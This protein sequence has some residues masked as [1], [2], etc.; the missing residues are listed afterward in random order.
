MKT[1]LLEQRVNPD[2]KIDP[3]APDGGQRDPQRWVYLV[4]K[5]TN[6]TVPRIYD[7]LTP[8]EADVYCDDDAWEVTIK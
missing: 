2:W 4:Q 3:T 6:S 8:A 7:T 1:L 5:V